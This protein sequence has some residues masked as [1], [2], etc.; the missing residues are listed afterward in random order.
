MKVFSIVL[1]VCCFEGCKGWHKKERQRPEGDECGG[2][3]G[4]EEERE[5]EK[6]T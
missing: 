2:C 5:E 1:G 4:E 6:G 3:R